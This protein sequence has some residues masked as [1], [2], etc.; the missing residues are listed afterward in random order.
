MAEQTPNPN[1]NSARFGI[2]KP[3]DLTDTSSVTDG[4]RYPDRRGTAIQASGSN[5]HIQ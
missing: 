3:L 4:H 2:S 5:L 1:G